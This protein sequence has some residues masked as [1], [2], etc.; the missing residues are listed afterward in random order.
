M[1]EVGPKGDEGRVGQ[2]GLPGK[3]VLRYVRRLI[4]A[5]CTMLMV[6]LVHMGQL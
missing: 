3:Q 2:R 6:R 5:N 1:G 4:W